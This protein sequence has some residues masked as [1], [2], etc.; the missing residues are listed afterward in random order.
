MTTR[1]NG[2]RLTVLIVDDEVLARRTLRA[3]LKNDP[4]IELIGECRSGKEALEFLFN[5]IPDLIFLDVQMPEINGF[6][7]LAALPKSIL[8][9]VIFVTAYDQFAVRAF[10]VHALDYLLKPFDDERF[11]KAL[12]RA[13]LEIRHQKE[14]RI[15]RQLGEFLNDLKKKEVINDNQRTIYSER[16]PVKNSGRIFFLPVHEIDWIEASDQYVTL[17]ADK[18]SYLI[19]ESMNQMEDH[20]PAN[21]FFRIHR[22]TLVNLQRVRELRLNRQG[23]GHVILADGTSLKI[24]RTRRQEFEGALLQCSKS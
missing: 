1:G 10:E 4:E 21:R 12:D 18:K 13:K 17:H 8:P 19:R 16:I 9:S 6:E 24:S 23:E 22:S 2:S 20:L 3:L 11:E 14:N 5:Q 15:T 7:V